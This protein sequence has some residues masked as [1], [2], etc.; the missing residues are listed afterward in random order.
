MVVDGVLSEPLSKAHFPA[1][2][3]KYR[4]LRASALRKLLGRI[5]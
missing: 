4:E 5:P 2:R 1:N 3:E